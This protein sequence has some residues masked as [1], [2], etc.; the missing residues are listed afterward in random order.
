MKVFN[1]LDTHTCKL[2]ETLSRDDADQQIRSN[3]GLS[4]IVQ[5]RCRLPRG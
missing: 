4:S 1:G 5:R 2:T 3:V